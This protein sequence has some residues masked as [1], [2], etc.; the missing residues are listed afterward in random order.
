MFPAEAARY[1]G[2]EFDILRRVPLVDEGV[3]NKG[4]VETE[5]QVA[6]CGDFVFGI[7]V[8]EADETTVTGEKK[9]NA[10]RKR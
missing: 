8:V 9:E 5:G 6:E 2:F 3:R 7:G 10:D 4:L 1:P